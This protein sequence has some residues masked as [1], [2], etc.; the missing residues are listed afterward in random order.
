VRI[1]LRRGT[2]RVVV[3]ARFADGTKRTVMR[4]I[5]GCRG[6]RRR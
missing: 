4:R 6:A 5:R 1:R 3:H 2:A